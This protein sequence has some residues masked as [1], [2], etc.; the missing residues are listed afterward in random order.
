MTVV[1]AA[2]L[3]IPSSTEADAIDGDWCDK[4]GRH[5]SV[6][7]PKVV[8]PLAR[9][10]GRIGAGLRSNGYGEVGLVA[11]PD[12]FNQSASSRD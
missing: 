6:D 1:L 2:L 3:V 10:P 9:L 4:N 12:A 7:G 5:M 8:T 11:G